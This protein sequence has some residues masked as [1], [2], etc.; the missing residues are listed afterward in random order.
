M[1]RDAECPADSPIGQSH[2]FTV[3]VREFERQ[4]QAAEKVDFLTRPARARRDAPF[5]MRRSRIVQNLNVPTWE[6]S[7]S[8]SSG[9]GG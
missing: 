7:C 9:L 3:T 1:N 2:A 5:P 4:R 6:K 8:D